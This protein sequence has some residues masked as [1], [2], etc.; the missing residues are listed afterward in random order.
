ML[1][2]QKAKPCKLCA[3][4]MPRGRLCG[5]P[6]LRRRT[7]CHFHMEKVQRERRIADYRIRAQLGQRYRQEELRNI[8]WALRN[9]VLKNLIAKGFGEACLRDTFGLNPDGSNFYKPEGEGGRDRAG[10]TE[11]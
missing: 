5:S 10:S 8:R 6:A 11:A 4:V 7:Y 9:P 2:P 3:Y 1:K